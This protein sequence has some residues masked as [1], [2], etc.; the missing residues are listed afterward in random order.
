MG[1]KPAIT[2]T[3]LVNLSAKPDVQH[4]RTA[5]FPV[6]AHRE[7]G[8]SAV[9][10][11][12]VGEKKQ[13]TLTFKVGNQEKKC[14]LT[15]QNRRW[16]SHLL[17]STL[18]F[19][20]LHIEKDLFKSSVTVQLLHQQDDLFAGAFFSAFSIYLKHLLNCAAAPCCHIRGGWNLWGK[21]DVWLRRFKTSI[22]F[23]NISLCLTCVNGDKWQPDLLF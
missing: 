5:S 19:R 3:L 20:K 1:V 18:T 12:F 4:H 14:S 10:T 15:F 9:I 7:I 2:I 22:P 23:L 16:L 17:E 6:Y 21:L 8:Y 13:R 11:L